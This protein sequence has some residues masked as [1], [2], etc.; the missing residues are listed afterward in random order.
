MKRL[1]LLSCVLFACHG[2]SPTEPEIPKGGLSGRVTFIES[3]APVINARITAGFSAINARAETRTDSSGRYRFDSLPFGDQYVVIAYLP[4][5]TEI[6]ATRLAIV[7]KESSSLDLQM[8]SSHCAWFNGFVRDQN[9]HHGISGAMM[10][11][12]GKTMTTNADG[13][14]SILLGCPPVP[15]SSSYPIVIEHPDYQ[16]R[17]FLLGV[18]SYTTTND[19]F[20]M[21][22]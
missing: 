8:S 7:G 1:L 22:R 15:S 21:P 5:S 4:D 12:F 17:E 16:R 18:P 3:A 14:F 6:G 11:F 13:S 10:S 2:H 9:T 19:I 20:L